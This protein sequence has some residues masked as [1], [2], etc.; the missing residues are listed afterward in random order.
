MTDRFPSHPG[1]MSA[2][3]ADLPEVVQ[4]RP[5]GTTAILGLVLYL[6]VEQ[7]RY[8]RKT[9]SS[10]DIARCHLPGLLAS[11]LVHS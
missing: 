8:Y 3:S 4:E 10:K 6:I 11:M 5:W 2:L 7:T 1:Y 9:V